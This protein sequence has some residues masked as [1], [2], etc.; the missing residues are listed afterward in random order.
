MAL[1]EWLDW[2]RAQGAGPVYAAEIAAAAK[3]VRDRFWWRS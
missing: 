3:A 2:L 1:G